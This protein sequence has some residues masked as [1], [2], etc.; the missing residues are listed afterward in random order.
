M[1]AL[2]FFLAFFVGKSSINPLKETF[3]TAEHQFKPRLASARLGN[4]GHRLRDVPVVSCEE[5]LPPLP[6]LL[7]WTP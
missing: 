6:L 4:G 5:M 3:D 1:V 7:L 2:F